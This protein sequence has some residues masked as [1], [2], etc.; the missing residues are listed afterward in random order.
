[1]KIIMFS[2]RDD[3][4]EAIHRWAE[5]NHTDITISQDVLTPDNV[6]LVE[7]FDGICLQQRVP[8]M[9]P[10]FYTKLA[11][12]GIKQITVR[13]AGYDIIDVN[14]ATKNNLI[15]SNVPAYSPH[16][17]AELII[18][19]TMRLIRNLALF[20]YRAE[21][22]DF[23]WAGL[24]AKEVR[25]LTVGIIGAGRIG[26]TAAGLFNG[27]GATV[28]AYDPVEREELKEIVTY[29]SSQ[30]EV[31]KEADVVTLHVPLLE[32]TI[33]LIDEKALSQMKP[34][35]YLLN[36]SRG[37]V[38]D[39]AALINA[40]NDDRLAGAALD[41]LTNEEHFF[42]FDLRDQE[43]QDENLK[44]LRKMPNVLLTPHVGF[45]TNIAVENMIDIS[46]N[47][48]LNIIQTG[49]CENRVN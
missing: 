35:S 47:D 31:L 48:V 45:Y 34:D 12:F 16:S 41:T 25:S 11:D 37:P 15:V 38:V 19:Q 33:G 23:R 32:E 10:L 8:I 28:I 27:L 39:T 44:A 49:T 40:L 30:E 3:E 2:V 42:N 6:D 1:M 14:E 4:E 13:T 36:A 18:A 29:K 5:R 43:L 17:V 9:D 24:K 46:L 26:G 7:G 20:D 22:Q 21:K